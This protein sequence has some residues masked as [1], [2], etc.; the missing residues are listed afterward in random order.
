MFLQQSLLLLNMDVADILN[1]LPS[2]NSEK[3][4]LFA[5]EVNT[6]LWNGTMMIWAKVCA[7]Q[8]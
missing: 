8:K 5:M 6:N 2:N 4:I 7:M 3:K 1:K